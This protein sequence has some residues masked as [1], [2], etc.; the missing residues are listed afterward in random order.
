MIEFL[1]PEPARDSS[2]EARVTAAAEAAAFAAYQEAVEQQLQRLAGM[3]HLAKRRA[4]VLALAEAAVRPDIS[5]RDVFKR[6]GVVSMK[7]FYSTDKDWGAGTSPTAVLF[8]EVIREVERLTLEFTSGRD[9]RRQQARRDAWQERVL[10]LVDKGMGKLEMMVDFPLSTVKRPEEAIIERDA[11]GRPVTVERTT[12]IQPA[13]WNFGTVGLL[14]DKFDR[15]ARLALE[16]DTDRETVQ[17]VGMSVE[18][19]RE[20]AEQRRAAAEQVL[21]EFEEEGDE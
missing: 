2:I 17:V 4:T 1:A 3:D 7:T 8:Q 11:E 19:W 20:Q 6:P 14:L 16:M 18:E 13:G 5:R 9:L 21:A 10:G 15:A 12:I